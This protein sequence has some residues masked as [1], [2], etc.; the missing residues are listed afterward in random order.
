[1]KIKEKTKVPK[2]QPLPEPTFSITGLTRDEMHFLRDLTGNFADNPGDGG[3]RN[4]FHTSLYVQICH[5]LKEGPRYANAYKFI[6][7]GSVF[8]CSRI[9]RH[10]E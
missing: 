9:G 7:T 5:I 6:A 4:H 2:P 10:P 1:M 8:H 3:I